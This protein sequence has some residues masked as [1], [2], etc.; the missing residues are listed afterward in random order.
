MEGE[1]PGPNYVCHNVDGSNGKWVGTWISPRHEKIFRNRKT[2]FGKIKIKVTRLL[3]DIGRFLNRLKRDVF[4]DENMAKFELLL[5]SKIFPAIPSSLRMIVEIIRPNTKRKKFSYIFL[6]VFFISSIVTHENQIIMALLAASIFD[7]FINIIP[8]EFEKK[9]SAEILGKIIGRMV[10]RKND[11]LRHLGV[12]PDPLA[13]YT[14]EKVLDNVY[15]KKK[16]DKI[17]AGVTH[18]KVRRQIRVSN[19][20]DRYKF[21]SGSFKDFVHYSYREN[22]LAIEQMMQLVGIEKYEHLY[23]FLQQALLIEVA[24]KENN[25]WFDDVSYYGNAES[26]KICKIND[27]SFFLIYLVEVVEFLF[28]KELSLLCS[29]KYG[30]FWTQM[31]YNVEFIML[32]KR[33][34]QPF[35]YGSGTLN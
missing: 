6:S 27:Y 4:S 25:D 15:C 26:E 10:E 17:I 16:V 35:Q 3:R 23:D 33:P 31:K 20:I 24:S 13:S 7:I 8:S 2:V 11:Q 29:Y 9:K 19:N 21:N 12:I 18:D 28:Y 30:F 32:T 5:V 34:F 1:R 22:K 14:G